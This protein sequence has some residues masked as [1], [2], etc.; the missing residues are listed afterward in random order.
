MGET[1]KIMYALGY[2]SADP[3]KK[4][5]IQSYIDEATEFMRE[6]GVSDDKL[7]SQRAFAVKSIWA[8]Y[9]DKGEYEKIIK[10]D[11]MIVALVAQL[12]R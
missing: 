5:Q 10:K 8:D 12:R 9:R 4:E 7:T 6:S 1:D 11:G 2:Y 3:R